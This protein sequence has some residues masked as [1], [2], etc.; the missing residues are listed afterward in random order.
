MWALLDIFVFVTSFAAGNKRAWLPLGFALGATLVTCIL[1][2]KSGWKWGTVET[3]SATGALIALLSWRKLGPRS[4]LIAVVVAMNISSIPAVCNAW[5]QTSHAGWWY[6]AGVS[7]C[8]LLSTYGA[9]AWTV[10]DR[11]FPATS[12]VFNFG[13]A[14]IL[15]L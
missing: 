2:S 10:K 4:A 13:M 8:S 14:T 9:S 15:L 7:F 3:I 12:C 5:S 6:W 11:L 1:Y